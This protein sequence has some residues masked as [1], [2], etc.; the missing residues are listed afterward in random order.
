MVA[1]PKLH[2]PAVAAALFKAV[3]V[4]RA[5]PDHILTEEQIAAVHLCA[6]VKGGG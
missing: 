6:E 1:L 4:R 2:D 5:A 3:D